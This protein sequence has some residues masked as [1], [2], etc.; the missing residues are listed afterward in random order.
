MPIARTCLP[1]FLIEASHSS[2]NAIIVAMNEPIDE[3]RAIVL[4]AENRWTA[5]GLPRVEMVKAEACSDQ[6]YRPMLHLVLQG[7]KSLSIGNQIL[8]LEPKTYFLVPVDLPAIGQVQSEPT[9]GPYLALSLVLNPEAIRAIVGDLKHSSSPGLGAGFSAASAGRELLDA[10][11]RMLRL[12]DCPQEIAILAP[13]IEREI[14]YRVLQGPYGEMLRQM[15]RVD[16][17]V[18]RVRR[19][20]DWIRSH[21]TEPFRVEPL[22]TMTGMSL[23]AF[24]RHFKAAT[25][26]SPIQYQK[27]LRLLEARRKLLFESGDAITTAFSVGYESP[28]QFSREYARM[29]GLPPLRDIARFRPGRPSLAPI[30]R[31]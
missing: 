29:F 12:M 28:S 30:S 9:G 15:A 7:T 26:M 3:L 24:Y 11:L 1:I 25:G 31:S 16:S 21:Y 4:R 18:S 22:A 10:W 20:T 23:A 8:R 6:V 19:A 27:K 14:L 5:T 17:R 2:P 13:L